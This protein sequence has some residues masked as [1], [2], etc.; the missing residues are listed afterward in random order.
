MMSLT[1][2][3]RRVKEKLGWIYK[4]DKDPMTDEIEQYGAYTTLFSS[5]HS[6]ATLTLVV[7]PGESRPTYYVKVV[8]DDHPITYYDYRDNYIRVRF[9]SG[10]V[11]K[12]IYTKINPDDS[13]KKSL[14]S[15]SL[16]I[17]RSEDCRE[18][19]ESC[20]SAK[21]ILIEIPLD[22]GGRTVFEYNTDKP[23]NWK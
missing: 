20:K 2:S 19:I 17:L 21:R 22:K 13:G 16:Y 7:T 11:N 15:R 14:Y 18:F 6:E 3:N 5:S 10:L 12:Y 1:P 4:E 23:L 9:D 8:V